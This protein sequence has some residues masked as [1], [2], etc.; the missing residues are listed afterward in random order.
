MSIEGQGSDGKVGEFIS[1]K[2]LDLKTRV[3]RARR[4][5]DK[6]LSRYEVVREG[7]ALLSL[8]D[9]NVMISVLA[10]CGYGSIKVLLVHDEENMTV[11]GGYGRA[12]DMHITSG[13]SFPIFRKY[14]AGEGIRILLSN[15]SH[16]ATPIQ[17]PPGV[18]VIGSN[19]E[20]NSLGILKSSSTWESG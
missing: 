1:V 17:R 14:I 20:G 12:T 13:K 8:E 10:P 3:E 5:V 9:V 11:E 19:V 2:V 4:D 15:V 7:I 16:L 18:L 6:I